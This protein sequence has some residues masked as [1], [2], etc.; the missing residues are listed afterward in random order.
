MSP[1]ADAMYRLKGLFLEMPGTRLTV[2]DASRL[3]GLDVHTCEA[4]LRGF[5][6][7][8]FLQRAAGERYVRRSDGAVRP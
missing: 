8:R 7:A 4:I 6:D 2:R 3:S 5:E 1:L